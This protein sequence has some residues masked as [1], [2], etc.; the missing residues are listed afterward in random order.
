MRS[1]LDLNPIEL[2]GVPLRYSAC[3]FSCSVSQEER[4]ENVRSM[5]DLK[6]IELFGVLRKNPGVFLL[7]SAETRA[8]YNAMH[9]VG[10][11]C[12]CVVKTWLKQ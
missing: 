7:E 9:K 12:V 8:R 11:A 3:L 1:M 5:L 6:P 4:A 10:S 2:V